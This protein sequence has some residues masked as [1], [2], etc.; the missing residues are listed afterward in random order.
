MLLLVSIMSGWVIFFVKKFTLE[1]CGLPPRRIY[2][3]YR[4]NIYFQF[5]L[6][7][8]LFLMMVPMGWMLTQYPPSCGPFGPFNAPF[9]QGKQLYSAY[10]IIPEAVS[11]FPEFARS[12]AS[13]VGSLAFVTI[14]VA[15]LG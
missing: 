12:I 5:F 2:N 9:G 11:K 8:T 10:A 1:K 6:L 7:F 13:F 14:M 15:V 3:S 4:Q